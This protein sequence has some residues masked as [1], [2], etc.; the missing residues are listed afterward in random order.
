M[1]RSEP[2][3][4]LVVVCIHLFFSDFSGIPLIL[5]NNVV[6]QV[7]TQ[8]VLLPARR[9]LYA[10]LQCWNRQDKVCLRTQEYYKGQNETQI[11]W[12]SCQLAFANSLWKVFKFPSTAI[13]NLK[14]KKVQALNLVDGD[15]FLLVSSGEE[16]KRT[17]YLQ[18]TA[19]WW[20][21]NLCISHEFSIVLRSRILLKNRTLFL[22]LLGCYLARRLYA[23]LRRQTSSCLFQK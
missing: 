11:R 21:C 3:D 17:Y 15:I 6:I 14:K 2:L 5:P 16:K 13:K 9:R 18:P 20:V 7:N 10:R 19:L 12:H 1:R 22:S 8:A 4:I 23:N